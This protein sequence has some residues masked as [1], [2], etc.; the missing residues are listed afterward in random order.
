MSGGPRRTEL[1]TASTFASMPSWSAACPSTA[2]GPSSTLLRALSPA[3]TPLMSHPAP[4]DVPSKATRGA[5]RSADRPQFQVPTTL[6][7]YQVGR[8][9]AR[10]GMSVVVEGTDPDRDEQVALK[11]MRPAADGR[12]VEREAWDREVSILSALRHP[13][14][15]RLLDS[16][17]A[18]GGEL[19]LVMPLLQGRSAR[20]EIV[21]MRGCD[22][23]ALMAATFD[24]LLPAFLDVCSTLQYAHDCGVLHCDLK[25]SNIFLV[26]GGAR[27]RALLLDWGVSV[28]G[29]HWTQGDRGVGARSGGTPGY[30]SPEQ[31]D[32]RVTD[33]D[34]RSDVYGLGALLYELCTWRPVFRKANPRSVL[35]AAM[36][37]NIVAPHVRRPDL[38]IPRRLSD[39]VMASLDRERINRPGSAAALGEAVREAVYG[40]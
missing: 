14:L 11:V 38:G 12:H 32:R 1:S 24:S 27:E 30:M 37:G 29:A 3:S 40:R 18:R 5:P 15:V 21:A 6:G 9:L 36:A 23:G 10:G 8:L 33:L 35:Q 4:T 25:P 28:I 31:I 34:V 13:G 19:Y 16:G 7:R 2:A 20:A 17:T 39:I 22:P 26:R